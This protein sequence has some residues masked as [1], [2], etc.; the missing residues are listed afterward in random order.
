M[1]ARLFYR[2]LARQNRSAAAAQLAFL[3]IQ[4]RGRMRE[5]AYFLAVTNIIAEFLKDTILFLT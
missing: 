3:R 1:S 4:L 5:K 2:T